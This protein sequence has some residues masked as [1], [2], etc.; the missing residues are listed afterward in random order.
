MSTINAAFQV[1]LSFV[2]LSFTN[3]QTKFKTFIVQIYLSHCKLL[4]RLDFKKR[5]SY[6]LA[7][8]QVKDFV[9]LNFNKIIL[10]EK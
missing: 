5:V 9:I 7:I 4:Y 2:S 6:L 8:F 10:N 3:T 1:E